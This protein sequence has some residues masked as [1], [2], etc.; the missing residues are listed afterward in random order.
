VMIVFHRQNANWQ[1]TFRSA[2]PL[3]LKVFPAWWTTI[4]ILPSKLYIIANIGYIRCPKIE[5]Y[6]RMGICSANFRVNALRSGP[7]LGKRQKKDP[8]IHVCQ[9]QI[10]FSVES[11]IT[12]RNSRPLE[13][14]AKD[15]SSCILPGMDWRSSWSTIIS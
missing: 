8:H 7:D 3:M 9:S 10:N 1:M 15:Q 4:L 14:S 12:L 6:P 5:E 11:D 13:K 2:S